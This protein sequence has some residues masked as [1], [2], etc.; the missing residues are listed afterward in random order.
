[1]I[2]VYSMEEMDTDTT[3]KDD[4]LGCPRCNAR[5]DLVLKPVG[6][7]DV[8]VAVLVCPKCKVRVPQLGFTTRA[9]VREQLRFDHQVYMAARARS[10]LGRRRYLRMAQETANRMQER[11]LMGELAG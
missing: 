8:M 4:E 9:M 11:S 10:E 6:H 3:A 5:A 1:M 7:G 2:G